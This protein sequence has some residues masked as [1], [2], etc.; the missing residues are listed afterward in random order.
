VNFSVFSIRILTELFIIGA[1]NMRIFN[2]LLLMFSKALPRGLK[3]WL[4]KLPVWP[5]EY[6][7]IRKG[8]EGKTLTF[9]EIKTVIKQDRLGYREYHS[10]CLLYAILQ[11]QK[12]N[13]NC[14]TVIELGVANGAGLLNLCEI[15]SIFTKATGINISVYGFDTGMGL[16]EIVDYR[17]HPEIWSKS[18]Y[19]IIDQQELIRKV[20][21]YEP[22][23][24]ADIIFG[25]VK[26][27]V[28]DFINDVL[29]TS[30][31]IGFISVDLDLYS[32][33]KP[34]LQLLTS[35]AEFYL[36]AVLM[37]VDDVESLITYN[38]RCGEKLAINEFNLEQGR[39]LIEKK[40]VRRNSPRKQWHEKIY[41]CH[42]LDHPIRMG[43]KDCSP[44]EINIDNY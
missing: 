5:I 14:I 35:N 39:R 38:S 22:D 6:I 10:L 36:P 20:K 27:T 41:V 40:L 25:N 30:S 28:P 19:K 9:D 23:I 1:N 34:S 11:S 24:K 29:S 21:S 37:Y 15:S 31:P 4:L 3:D 16:P 12:M 33:T 26:D 17:D 8:R 43:K 13:L 18:K 7:K 42:I 2:K 44:F 32:S